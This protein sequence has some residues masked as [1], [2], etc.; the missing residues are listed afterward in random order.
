MRE[1]KFRGKRIDDGEWVDGSLL[2]VSQNKLAIWNPASIKSTKKQDGSVFISKMT[3]WM[4]DPETVGQWTGL[5][6]KNGVD[7]YEGDELRFP[8]QSKN[9]EINFNSFE[10]F[11]HDNDCTPTD[12]GLVLGRLKTHGISA[13]GCF[14][15]KLKPQDVG[16]MEIIGNIHSDSHM[17]DNHELLGQ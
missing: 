2:V 16:R 3:Y 7:I 6:D 9:C 14:G 11:W 13:G 12:V 5:T 4:V 1:I 15:F 17:L 10:V 8:A